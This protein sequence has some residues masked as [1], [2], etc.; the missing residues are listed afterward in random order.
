MD[1]NVVVLPTVV[2]RSCHLTVVVEPF[3][4]VVEIKQKVESCYGIPVT[5]QRLLF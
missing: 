1:V 4:K 2:S 5:M 3:D